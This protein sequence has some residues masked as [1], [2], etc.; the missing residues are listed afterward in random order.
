MEPIEIVVHVTD[1]DR[2]EIK[3][4]VWDYGTD[5]SPGLDGFTLGF[6]HRYRKI[7]ESDVVNAEFRPISLIRSLYKIIAKLVPNRIVV[8]LGSL[9]N[10]FKKKQSLVFKVDF[11][12]AYDSV[13]WDYLDDILRIFDFG[14]KWRVW[15]RNFLRSSRGSVIMNGRPTE[16]FQFY[17][18]ADMFN[19]IS[20]DPSLHLSHMLYAN[21][22]IFVG[23]WNESN[24]N[25]IVHV[26]DF[27]HRASG[28]HINMS[29][30]KILGISMDAKKVDQAARKIGCVTLQTPFKYLGL[31]VGGLMSRI[32]SWNEMVEV[33]AIHGGDGKIGK[34][35][36]STFLS[37][38]LD[39]VHEVEL[40]KDRCI[41]LI[42]FIHKKLKNGADTLFWEDAWRGRIAFKYLY[43]I[44]YALESS[45]NIDV[46]SKMAHCNLGYSF[47]RDHRGGVKKAQFDLML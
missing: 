15:I 43:P 16:E 9:V 39:I 36:K 27:F 44:V 7:I 11:E 45:K 20:L 38:W 2:D 37:L 31:K 4:A 34:K 24:I 12:K 33:K 8:V 40:L 6:Y 30:S 41:D 29:K 3:R 21:D 25:T 17:K 28:L 42:S 32:Q 10:E 1:L 14:D 18:D 13:R 23:Q 46:T 19:G 26:L 35:A 47:R 22:A 5:K